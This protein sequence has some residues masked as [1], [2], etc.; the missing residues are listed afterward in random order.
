MNWWVIP[1]LK[2]AHVYTRRAMCPY[3]PWTTP[4]ISML[5]VI[6]GPE[7]F[8]NWAS[9]PSC[10]QRIYSSSM[11]DACQFTNF[12]E[13]YTLNK[14]FLSPIDQSVDY[15]QW[16]ALV[17]LLI[18]RALLIV[19]HFYN[20]QRT[21]Q[22]WPYVDSRTLSEGFELQSINSRFVFKT[23]CYMCDANKTRKAWF[24][25]EC[26]P[27]RL[28]CAGPTAWGFCR[29]SQT[30]CAHCPTGIWPTRLF[31]YALWVCARKRLKL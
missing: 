5:R 31:H 30:Q 6:R 3:K 27:Y 9:F 4:M 21:S 13:N 20:I 1:S 2:G 26:P 25:A 23:R 7:L 15:S 28:C 12:T 11:T 29:D 8:Q 10:Y 16:M 24:C 19:N 17:A 18:L 22:H 14:K